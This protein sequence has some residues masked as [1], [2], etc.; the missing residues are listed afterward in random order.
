VKAARKNTRTRPATVAVIEAGS[1]HGPH[2]ASI[3]GPRAAVKTVREFAGVLSV[4]P[5]EAFHLEKININPLLR[6]KLP[7]AERS[8]ARALSSEE[9]AKLREAGDKSSELWR[10]MAHHTRRSPTL[11]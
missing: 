9:T 10:I 2:K 6:L 4:A 1:Y 8:E 5:N 3:E 7:N 11:N